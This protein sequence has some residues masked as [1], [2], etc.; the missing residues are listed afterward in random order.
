MK[1]K[2][3]AVMLIAMVLLPITA[4]AASNTYEIGDWFSDEGIW[5]F[6]FSPNVP[7]EFLESNYTKF[8]FLILPFLAVWAIVYGIIDELPLF[9][10]NK[11][12]KVL[13]AFIIAAIAGPTGGLV[14]TVH[15]LFVLYGQLAVWGFIIILFVGTIVW[16]LSGLHE[17]G[18]FNKGRGWTGKL[19]QAA[20]NMSNERKYRSKLKDLRDQLEFMGTND[21]DYKRIY[22]E[23]KRTM[24]DYYEIREN[25]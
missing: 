11:N 3:F 21:P 12:L 20:K 22:E 6:L 13:L 14:W 4:R 2:I 23:Y 9:N 1:A 19:D 15:T 16:Q 8:Q 25:G 7:D 24:K 17:I 10:R 5:K 18:I